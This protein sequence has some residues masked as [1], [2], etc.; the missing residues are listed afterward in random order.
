MSAHK[1]LSDVHEYHRDQQTE[2]VC[3]FRKCNNIIHMYNVHDIHVF[4]YLPYMYN[5]Y[6]YAAASVI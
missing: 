3:A 5:G 6:Q 1:Q 4:Q 2:Q